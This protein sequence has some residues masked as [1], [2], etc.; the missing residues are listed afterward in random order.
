MPPKDVKSLPPNNI[1]NFGRPVGI[2]ITFYTDPLC[3]WTWAMQPQWKRLL[4]YLEG[5]STIMVKYKMGGL[6]PS[7]KHFNDNIN[8][9][10]KPVQMGPEW[11]H[12][13]S[14]S[15]AVIHDR[16]WITDPPASSF[17]A[18]IAVKCAEFQSSQIAAHYFYL[19]QEAVMVK[20][21]N[22]SKTNVLLDVAS[23]IR[24]LYSQFDLQKFKED[25]LGEQGKEVFR[26]DLQE[27]KYLNIRR[28]PT[29]LFKSSDTVPILVSGY[30]SYESLKDACRRLEDPKGVSDL[31][32]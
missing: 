7:W 3:C 29:I 4:C 27:C 12:A 31:P 30:Q 23:T 11:M 5:F 24:T 14:L 1:E 9:I 21:L 15:G 16:I 22:I 13:R 2:E 8:S 6:L 20:N 25:L 26:K 32:L 28:M 10:Q 19:L 18:C 17:P